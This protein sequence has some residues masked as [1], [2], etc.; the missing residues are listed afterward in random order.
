[1]GHAPSSL[2]RANGQNLR[3]VTVIS[4][5][6]VLFLA[7][8]AGN[9][10][11]DFRQALTIIVPHRVDFSEID[12]YAKR[13]LAAYGTANS[14]RRQFP[15]TTRIKTIKSIDVLYFIETDRERKQQ[16]ISVRGTANDPNVFQDIEVRMVRDKRLGIY[17]H[18]GFRDDTRKVHA[19]LKPHLRNGYS[20][21][22]T[23]HSLGGAIAM[24]LSGY[25]M[26][27]GHKVERLVTFGQP[28]VTNKTGATAF[29][30]NI[31]RVAN[32][33]DVV[34]MLPPSDFHLGPGGAYEHVGPEVVLRTGRKYV[35]LPSHEADRVSVGQFWRNASD[36][37][38]R[39]H[40]MRLYLQNIEAKVRTGARQ[41]PYFGPTRSVSQ[42]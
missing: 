9:L 4:I 16:R 1:M 26:K 6:S 28:K 29:Q 37:S 18:R 2:D 5:I 38:A 36:F 22:V 13:S 12:F 11:Q 39:D 41:V 21:Q 17:L 40:H 14:I 3:T 31:T 20:M 25:L 42:R 8:C 24:V 30:G 32:E 33:E 35:Y 27:D 19:D 15:Q 7:G 10:P 34:P 23:G